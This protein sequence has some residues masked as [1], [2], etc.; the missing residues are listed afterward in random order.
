MAGQRG[1]D[2]ASLIVEAVERM[3]DHEE[4]F[5]REV[6]AGLAQVERGNTLSHE[7]VGTSMERH[8]A[9]KRQPA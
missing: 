6:E 1:R 2:A 9:R 5:R 3:V 4:W 7:E 8:L